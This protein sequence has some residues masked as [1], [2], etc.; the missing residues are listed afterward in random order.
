[1]LRWPSRSL[2]LILYIPVRNDPADGSVPYFRTRCLQNSA[3]SSD[4][5]LP[6]GVG[7]GSDDDRSGRSIIEPI[8][9]P[10]T[11][12]GR[13]SALPGCCRLYW[14]E[15]PVLICCNE[16]IGCTGI[17]GAGRSCGACGTCDTCDACGACGRCRVCGACGRCGACGA[18]GPCGMCYWP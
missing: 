7:I 16:W 2:L 18:Y 15:G 12:G 4:G 10:E 11:V 14:T 3:T 17:N 8:N 1:M 5:S 6:T 9:D 13:V